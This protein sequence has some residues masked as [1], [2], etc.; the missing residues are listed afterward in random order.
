MLKEQYKYFRGMVADIRKGRQPLNG[1]LLARVALY[2][3]AG[4]KTY[5]AIRVRAAKF[6]GKMRESRR[7]LGIS[8]HCQG[9]L[10]EAKKGWGR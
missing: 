1:T 2:G 4:R 5:E 7:V 6:S 8:D 9:C 3:Q 10:R